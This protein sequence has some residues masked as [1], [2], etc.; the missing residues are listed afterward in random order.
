MLWG[1]F[2]V[3]GTGQLHRIKWT[4]EG[5]M[6]RQGQDIENGSEY[7]IIEFLFNSMLHAISL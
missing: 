5:A 1:C 2:S 4:M 7:S 3:K 6:Y